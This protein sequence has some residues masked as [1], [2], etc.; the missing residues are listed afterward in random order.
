MSIL[1]QNIVPILKARAFGNTA[2]AVI[3]AVS[4]DSRSLQN[5]DHFIFSHWLAQ[6]MMR[7]LIKDL[8]VTGVQNFVVLRIPD[9][10]A[11]KAN[12]LIVENTLVALQQFATYYRSL[13]IFPLL[14]WEVMVKR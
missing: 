7:I 3:D 8:I 11:D 4:I 10:C 2:E 9:G 5:S 14:V 12:F 6:I 13:F 1:I